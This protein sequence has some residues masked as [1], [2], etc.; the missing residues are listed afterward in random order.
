MKLKFFIMLITLSAIITAQPKYSDISSYPGSFSRLGFGARGMG[1]ANAMGAVYTGSLVSYYN[2]ALSAF[3]SKNSAQVGY[4]FLSLD[5]SLNFANFTRNFEFSSKDSTK[6]GTRA[7]GISIGVINAGVSKID[8]RDNQGIS[9]GDLSTSEN[10]FFIGLANKFSDKFAVG[11]AVKLYY[12]HLYDKINSTTMGFDIGALYIFNK[13]L[14]A[15][16][17]LTDV[18]SKYKWDTTDLYG[19]E[20]NNEE[21]KFPILKKISVAYNF[22]EPKILAVAEIENSNAKT[23]YLRFGAE[24]NIYEN[25]YLR[26]GVDKINLNNSDVST[27]PS[28]GFSYNYK[29]ENWDFG[30]DYA[31]IYEPYSINNVHVI[32][33][34]F[35]L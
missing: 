26:C 2:P 32:G 30:F 21:N 23:N 15:A 20:G 3:Q 24:Y 16:F 33:L 28:F 22:I 27:R 31:Y 12:F 6:K 25:L 17:V 9:T 34:N 18:N 5:R 29:F 14:S 35:I 11:I 1:M 4:S 8:G 10:Q 19:Q 13:N 7:A